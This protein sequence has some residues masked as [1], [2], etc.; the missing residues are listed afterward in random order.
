MPCVNEIHHSVTKSVYQPAEPLK[1][2]DEV[3]FLALIS[4]LQKME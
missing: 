1:S 3:Q 4:G 2:K